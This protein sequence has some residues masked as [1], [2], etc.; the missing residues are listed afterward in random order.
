MKAGNRGLRDPLEGSGAS[1]GGTEGGKHLETQSSGSASTKQARIAE[2]A[3]RMTWDRLNAILD[4]FP[5]PQAKVT[6]SIYAP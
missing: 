1:H 2:R 3:G 5:L 6:R 4:R